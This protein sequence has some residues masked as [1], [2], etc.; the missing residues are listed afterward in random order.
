[1]PACLRAI[2]RPR[3]LPRNRRVSCFDKSSP[4]R[5]EELVRAQLDNALGIKHLI[6]RDPN[7]GR[8]E[9]VIVESDDPKIEAARKAGD[10]TRWDALVEDLGS[11]FD[12]MREAY[13]KSA[14]DPDVRARIARTL[15]EMI[16]GVHRP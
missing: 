5:L 14:L 6:M 11:H 8:F 15:D 13:L 9:R 4:A 12:L 10:Q 2:R 7:T 1:M 16:K 3:R